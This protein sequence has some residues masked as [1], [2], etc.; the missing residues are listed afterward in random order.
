MGT[1]LTIVLLTIFGLLLRGLFKDKS[2]ADKPKDTYSWIIQLGISLLVGFVVWSIIPTSCK[3]GSD[4]DPA[5][6]IIKSHL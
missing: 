3:K 4:S 1:I 6:R 5:D 2:I